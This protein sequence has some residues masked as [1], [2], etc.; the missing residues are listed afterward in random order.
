MKWSFKRRDRPTT[1]LYAPIDAYS[2]LK[3]GRWRPKLLESELF[4]ASLRHRLERKTGLRKNLP[5]KCPWNPNANTGLAPRHT[6]D[7]SEERKRSGL[8]DQRLLAASASLPPSPAPARSA[9][10]APLHLQ[11]PCSSTTRLFQE[12]FLQGCFDSLTRPRWQQLCPLL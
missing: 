2:T 9:S 4:G 7:T 5:R 1:V 12:L 11:P 6:L 8:R 3:G 10:R